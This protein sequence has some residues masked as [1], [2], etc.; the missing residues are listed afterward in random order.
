MREIEIK[1]RIADQAKTLEKLKA[2]GVA[3]GKPL[4]QHDV[5]YGQRKPGNDQWG[6]VW[7]RI[8]TENDRK[9]I[10]TLKKDI[11]GQF[12][13]LEHELEVSS[14]DEL[15]AILKLLDFEVY[16][17][18]TKIRAK[19]KLGKMEICFDTVPGLG[20]FLEAELLMAHDADHDAVVQKLW[21]FLDGLDVTEADQVHDGY[22]VMMRQK[23]G[24]SSVAA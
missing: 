7:L 22:D 18:L 2:S 8:R 23:Q 12:D 13:C 4:K 17:D 3:L 9:V 24:A 10:F 16:S 11:V 20:N 19:G 21:Q 1:V 15:A 5:V 6:T 14:A